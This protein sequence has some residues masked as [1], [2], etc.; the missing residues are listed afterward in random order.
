MITMTCD[1]VGMQIFPHLLW[2]RIIGRLAMPIYAYMIA[3]GCRH[4]RDRRKY[5]LRLL[6]MGVLCQ[7]VYLVAMGSLYQCILITFSLSVILICLM[8]EAERTR[9]WGRLAAG[10]LLIFFLCTVL[11]DLLSHTDF[12]IDYGL[13]GVLLPVLIY[14]AGTRGLL[15]GLALVA[16]KYGGVQWLAFLAVPLLLLY[17]GQRGTAKIGKLFYWY[18]PI[19]LVAIYGLSL[20]L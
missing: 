19:H 5:L 15:I 13:P 9:K 20:I 14:G 10:T 1:H 7:A 3:E 16:L 12:E 2:L 8:D 17:N 6:G 18:Y 11:P 4:T